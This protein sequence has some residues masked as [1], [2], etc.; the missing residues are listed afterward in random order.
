MHYADYARYLAG[1]VWKTLTPENMRRD[2]GKTNMGAHRRSRAHLL[3]DRD[4]R[5]RAG[6]EA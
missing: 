5:R 6:L 3:F 4:A 1:D 2:H